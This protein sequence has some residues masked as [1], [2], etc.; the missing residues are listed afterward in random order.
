MRRFVALMVI[1]GVFM[2]LPMVAYAHECIVANRS[3]AGAENSGNA[4]VW[5]TVTTDDVIYFV[6]EGDPNV[7]QIVAVYGDAYR[8]AVEEAGLP[9]S[10]SIFS[11]LTLGTVPTTGE[12]TPAYDGTGRSGDLQGIDHLFSGGLADTYVGLLL[13]LIGP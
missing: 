6:F 13:A 5:E 9:T 4:G 12:F 3:N 11:R 10:F 7:E 8:E 2:S 1:V